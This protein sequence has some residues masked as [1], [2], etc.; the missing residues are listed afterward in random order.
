MKVPIEISAR[1]LHISAKDLDKLFGKNYKLKKRNPLIQ[2]GQFAAVETVDL[3][4][5]KNKIKKVR[6]LGPVR[7]NSQLEISKTDA[8]NLGVNTPYSDSG[9][10]KGSGIVLIGK[11][12]KL[13]MNKGV[14]ISLRHLHCNPTEAKRLKLKNGQKIAVRVGGIRALVFENV[15]VREG[16]NYSLS[17]HL[18]TDEGNAAGINGK[19][20]GEII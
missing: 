2:P 10:S 15:L 11:R 9:E 18:D 8:F 13:K 16:D 14:M 4:Y 17:L 7:E 3:Q 12:G 1:H 20:E 6:I 5:G 19:G